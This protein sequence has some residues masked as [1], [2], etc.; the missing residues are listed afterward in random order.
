[1]NTIFGIILEV[2]NRIRFGW[3]SQRMMIEGRQSLQSYLIRTAS[4][5]MLINDV[6]NNSTSLPLSGDWFF[7]AI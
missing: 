2:L 5:H 6:L 7:Y 1:M 3:I 4:L